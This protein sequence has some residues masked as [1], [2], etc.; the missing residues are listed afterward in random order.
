M[1]THNDRHND[2]NDIKM[3]KKEEKPD[4]GKEKSVMLT[5]QVCRCHA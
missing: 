3:D 2:A 4:F 5:A 1:I